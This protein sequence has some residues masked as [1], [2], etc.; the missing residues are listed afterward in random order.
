MR[1]ID[2]FNGDADGICA[3]HQLRLADPIESRLVTGLK[4]DIALLDRVDAGEGDLVTVLDI[5]LDRNRAALARLLGRGALV[6]YFDHH[7][8]GSITTHPNLEVHID[9]SG[10]AC[11]SAL[12]NRHLWGRFREWAVVGAFGDGQDELARSIAGP[13]ADGSRP[14]E[15]LRD[16][17]ASLNYNAYGESEA[18][19]IFPPVE[20]YRVVHRYADP[21]ELIRREPLIARISQQR[22]ADLERAL[23]TEPLR[24]LPT[25]EAYVLPDAAWSRRVSGTF[26]NRLAERDPRRAHA[27]LTPLQAGGYVVS[28]R[29]PREWNVSAAD[30]CRR[31]PTGGGRESA[32]GIDHLHAERI[33]P[34]LNAFAGVSW[35]LH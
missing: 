32:A 14:L 22:L 35:S 16:L 23:E 11:T 3:L 30:F 29:S 10:A 20:L 26:A 8:A 24:S 19:P 17:G 27:V 7:F 31:F 1:Y 18:D 4:R 13:Q 2:V 25:L 21:F 6:H 12:V 34:F 5:S 9:A 15:A 28:V 33:E